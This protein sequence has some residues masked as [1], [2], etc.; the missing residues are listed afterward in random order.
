MEGHHDHLSKR[1][2]SDAV[3]EYQPQQPSVDHEW[4]AETKRWQLT[5]AAHAREQN[6]LMILAKIA[7][8][9]SQSIRA[10]REALLGLPGARDR[11]AEIDAEAIALRAN[12]SLL[13]SSH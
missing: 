12:L 13:D 10:V 1:V 6:R 5:V 11:L 3:V 2:E 7:A 4:D 9:D 8:L